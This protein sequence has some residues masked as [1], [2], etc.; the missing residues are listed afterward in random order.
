MA[1][2]WRIL[3]QDE[4]IFIVTGTP[5][6]HRRGFHAVITDVQVQTPDL[7]ADN[8]LAHVVMSRNTPDESLILPQNEIPG[9]IIAIGPRWNEERMIAALRRG[10]AFA[11]DEDMHAK[12]E[13]FHRAIY[14]RRGR[15]VI[16]RQG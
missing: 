10:H 5:F 6:L 11:Y 12:L 3:G 2:M 9:D 14:R 1:E 4:K 15:R 7:E 8:F 16:A 13:E